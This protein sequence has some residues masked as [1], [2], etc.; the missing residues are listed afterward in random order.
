MTIVDDARTRAVPRAKE[1][2]IVAASHS[3]DQPV[4]DTALFWRWVASA[5]RP[6]VRSCA[7]SVVRS[8]AG[9]V[10]RSRAATAATLVGSSTAPAAA[11]ERGA[12][13][14]QG[15]ADSQAERGPVL[16]IGRAGCAG[17][18]VRAS[19]APRSVVLGRTDAEAQAE[20]EEAARLVRRAGPHLVG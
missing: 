3:A 7:G 8:R 15:K 12:A 16:V 17:R 1:A 13:Q 18:V 5:T 9:S 10:V 11:V 20:A 6:V 19:R 14:A 4:P 2:P